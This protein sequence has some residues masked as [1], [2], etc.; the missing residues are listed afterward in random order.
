M[1]RAWFRPLVAACA[2]FWGVCGCSVLVRNELDKKAGTD[3]LVV[4][5]GGGDGVVVPGDG[6][7]GGDGLRPLDGGPLPN[8]SVYGPCR[9]MPLGIQPEPAGVEQLKAARGP[10]GSLH[11]VYRQKGVL[12][13]ERMLPDS[14]TTAGPYKLVDPA[15]RAFDYVADR[16]WSYLAYL[17]ADSDPAVYWLEIEAGKGPRYDTLKK[18]TEPMVTQV[19][20]RQLALTLGQQGTVLLVGGDQ[21]AVLH[22]VGG[23]FSGDKTCRLGSSGIRHA[24]P[25]L[26]AS[27]DG[28]WLIGSAFSEG[29]NGA[30]RGWAFAAAPAGFLCSDLQLHPASEHPAPLAFLATPLEVAI[31]SPLPP[32]ANPTLHFSWV[33]AL[34]NQPTRAGSLMYMTSAW[35]PQAEP[36]MVE[37]EVAT[38]NISLGLQPEGAAAPRRRALVGYRT[39]SFPNTLR[40]RQLP[41]ALDAPMLPPFGGPKDVDGGLFVLPSGGPPSMATM[42]QLL[43]VADVTRNGGELLVGFCD[44]LPPLCEQQG[45]Q[46]QGPG[47]R[48]YGEACDGNDF[49]GISCDSLFKGPGGLVCSGGCGVLDTR[50]CGHYAYWGFEESNAAQEGQEFYWPGQ[51]DPQQRRARC[52]GGSCPDPDRNGEGGFLKFGARSERLTAGLSLPQGDSFAVAFAFNFVS[53][54][55]GVKQRVLTLSAGAGATAV[56]LKCELENFGAATAPDNVLVCEVLKGLVYAIRLEASIPNEGNKPWRHVVVQVAD[57]FEAY[58]LELYVDGVRQAQGALDWATIRPTGLAFGAS[59]V[60]AT[61]GFSG[62]I[63]ELVVYGRFLDDQELIQF[64]THPRQGMRR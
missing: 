64:A 61:D 6:P 28:D 4:D 24:L 21:G 47:M 45:G 30:D 7:G 43:I 48:D 39:G 40:W 16:D 14:G 25:R 51:P 56:E 32:Q 59:A 13:L 54:G 1:S 50:A 34:A 8:E 19:V 10:D 55:P 33:M 12:W 23:S 31:E 9:F 57:R 46:S 41:F 52:A 58:D 36:L 3:G 63:D 37:A 2:A 26:A 27:A 18:I 62:A 60:G 29:Q 5:S 15:P 20:P 22:K 42:E 11:I 53:A 49:G 38:H 35:Y 44:L 17:G